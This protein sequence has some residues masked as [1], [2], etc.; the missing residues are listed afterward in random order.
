MLIQLIRSKNIMK[1]YK[2]TARLQHVYNT[3][4]ARLVMISITVSNHGFSF[5]CLSVA[6]A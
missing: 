4:S 5:G 6:Q 3:K 1:F 2:R